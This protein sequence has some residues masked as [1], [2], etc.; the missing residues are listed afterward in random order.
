MGNLGHVFW[1][2]GTLQIAH[3]DEYN[4]QWVLPET[5]GTVSK[6]SN[7][8]PCHTPSAGENVPAQI[9]SCTCVASCSQRKVNLPT[10]LEN[11]PRSC[12]SH[13]SSV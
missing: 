1:V 7:G 12:A 9:G 2:S 5:P 8:R 3:Y 10:R 4:N 13:A 6:L 11:G